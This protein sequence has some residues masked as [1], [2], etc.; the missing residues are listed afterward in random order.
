M[1]GN[2]GSISS[3]ILRASYLEIRGSNHSEVSGYT[4]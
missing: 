2:E 3:D 4:G 1:F